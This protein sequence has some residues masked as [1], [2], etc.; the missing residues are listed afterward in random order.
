MKSLLK[1]YLFHDCELLVS[2]ETINKIE[3]ILAPLLSE[4][5]QRPLIT[6]ADRT[7]KIFKYFC[8][9]AAKIFLSCVCWH[10]VVT[11]TL[12]KSYTKPEGDNSCR[13]D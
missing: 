6:P 10:I 9:A 4:G 2:F 3:L 5:D 11:V 12:L 13:E 8:V 7:D 1:M